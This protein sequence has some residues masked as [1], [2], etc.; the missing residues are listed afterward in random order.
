[1]KVKKILGYYDF[2]LGIGIIATCIM[3]MTGAI[4]EYPTEWLG[5]TPF[6]NWL[7][8]SIIGIII[9][10]VCNIFV[11]QLIFRSKSKGIILSGIMGILLLVSILLSI[12][13]LADVY[14][15]TIQIMLLSLVQIILTIVS[16]N[17]NISNV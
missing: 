16:Y 7:Y 2:I 12:K 11:S 10:G 1:M 3:M 13:V 15:I 6:T 4:G 8:P 5:K 14:L 9:Y 17:K